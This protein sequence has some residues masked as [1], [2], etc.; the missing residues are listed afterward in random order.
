MSTRPSRAK[1]NSWLSGA[2]LNIQLIPSNPADI[3]RLGEL[4]YAAQRK[5][6][7]LSHIAGELG[8]HADADLDFAWELIQDYDRENPK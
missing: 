2:I 3:K 6:R 8:W 1:M 7:S 4:S 5:L